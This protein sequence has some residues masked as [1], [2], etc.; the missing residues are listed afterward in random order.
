MLASTTAHAHLGM[1][2]GRTPF[3]EPD[4]AL[5]GAATSWGIVE[6]ES[7]GW[8]RVCEEALGGPPSFY[9]RAPASDRVLVGRFD[10][11]HFTDDGGCTLQTGPTGFEEAKPTLL[12]VA[13][14]EPTTL[15]VATS[16]PDAINRVL[17]S[18]DGGESFSATQLSEQAARFTSIMTSGD[19]VRVWLTAVTETGA[20]TLMVSSDG[21][22]TFDAPAA[23]LPSDATSSTLVGYDLESNQPR[24]AVVRADVAG[25]TLF[26]LD[27]DGA[28]AVQE[29]TFDALVTDWARHGD[30]ELVVVDRALLF[31]RGPQDAAFVERDTPARCLV[32]APL[33]DVRLYACAMQGAGG[34]FFVT[35]EGA[36]WTTLL[37]F[38]DVQERVCPD[39]T[40]GATACL[41]RVTDGGPQPDGGDVDLTRG[42]RRPS[43]EEPSAMCACTRVPDAP[44]GLGLL[45]LLGVIVLSRAKRSRATV[46]RATASPATWSRASRRRV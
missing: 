32:R 6:L 34:H 44:R 41:F 5:S 4:F 1:A 8:Q 18:V 24:L 26:A 40:P 37:P 14:D 28:A 2:Q 46:S 15:Y 31:G 38:E 9:Y 21:G 17:K 12:A 30:H 39:G 23:A 25:S 19:G 29:A 16:S 35:E 22:A 11:L 13:H 36:T 42:S 43:E 3:L 45:L 33:D 20:L 7:D 10:G 27:A